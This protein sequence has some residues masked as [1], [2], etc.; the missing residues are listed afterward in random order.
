MRTRRLLSVVALGV[1]PL[2]MGSCGSDSGGKAADKVASTATTAPAVT[3][4]GINVDGGT[5]Q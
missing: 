5:V 1:V 4:Q 3:G 2:V